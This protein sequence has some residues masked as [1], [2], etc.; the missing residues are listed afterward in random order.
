MTGNSCAPNYEELLQR[1]RDTAWKCSYSEFFL[2]GKIQTKKT[3]NMDTFY[4]VGKGVFYIE[5]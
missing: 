3:S 2:S 4:A 5:I 1:E